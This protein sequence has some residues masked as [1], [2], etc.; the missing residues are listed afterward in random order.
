[1]RTSLCCPREILFNQ[2]PKFYLSVLIYPIIAVG[3]FA[4]PNVL[5]R[6]AFHILYCFFFWQNVAW[7]FAVLWNETTVKTIYNLTLIDLAGLQ[8]SI[9]PRLM[10]SFGQDIMS[11][12]SLIPYKH[13]QWLNITPFTAGSH[14]FVSFFNSILIS[15][16]HC[17]KSNP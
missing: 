17:W 9:F 12:C 16:W 7:T 4:M 1:M 15:I 10:A 11:S 5:W 8:I 3:C 13:S 2:Q 14:S 6:W